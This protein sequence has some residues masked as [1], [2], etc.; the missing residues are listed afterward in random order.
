MGLLD[1]AKKLA[2]QARDLAGDTMERTRQATDRDS[3]APARTPSGSGEFGTPAGPLGEQ[4]KRLG[5]ADP[6]AMVKLVE[7]ERV[8]V[9]G[10]TKSVVVQESYGVGRRWS[11]DG[12][13]IGFLWL[14]DATSPPADSRATGA[15]WQALRDPGAADV[16]GL[17]GD[18]Y[19]KDA[20]EGRR[21][22]FVRAGDMGFVVEVSGLGD[23]VAV[24][25]A[26]GAAREAAEG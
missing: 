22:V 25:L 9:A 2:Q 17:A 18:G 23:D 19:V 24:D 16:G 3:E 5:L 14:I 15:H 4:W 10:S 8:G 21:G 12:K 20:G 1:K 6:A 7:R 26:R 11:A 13:S